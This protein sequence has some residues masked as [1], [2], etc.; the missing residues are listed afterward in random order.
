MAER[1]TAAE[2]EL[3]ILDIGRDLPQTLGDAIQAAADEA[4]EIVKR[5]MDFKTNSPG[6][7]LASI[8][9]VFDENTMTLGI[10]MPEHGYFQNFGVIAYLGGDKLKD[11]GKLQGDQEPIDKPTA[12]AFGSGEGSYMEFGTKNYGNGKGWGAY[13]TGLDA[14][15]FLDTQDFIKNVAR[16]VNENLELV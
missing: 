10:S 2:I 8:K 3:A 14:K 4:I 12:V 13:Y 6:G 9:A 1:L 15:R 7:V 5:K 16:I 11:K